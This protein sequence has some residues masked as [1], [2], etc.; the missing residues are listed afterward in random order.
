MSPRR[1]D[2][3]LVSADNGVDPGTVLGRLRRSW[4]IL[5]R[6]DVATWAVTPPE[7]SRESL[8]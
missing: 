6:R 7:P 5:V 2:G 8:P 1:G 4:G 3:I